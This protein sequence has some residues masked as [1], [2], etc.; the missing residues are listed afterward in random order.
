MFAKQMIY[1]S[2]LFDFC[3]CV[4]DRLQGHRAD[5]DGRSFETKFLILLE[6]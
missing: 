2:S 3:V 4:S 5:L 1:L 6:I